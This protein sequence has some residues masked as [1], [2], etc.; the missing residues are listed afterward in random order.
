MNFTSSPTPNSVQSV[1]FDGSVKV[2]P[3]PASGAASLE[4]ELQSARTVRVSL[5]DAV[6]R[7]VYESAQV[8]CPAG[9]TVLSIPMETLA[10]GVHL[11]RVQD[12]KE[13]LLQSGQIGKQ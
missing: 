8:S 1:R 11:Y 4:L 13:G 2:Y 6:G 10:A 7:K 9:R 12:A 3:N 5:T